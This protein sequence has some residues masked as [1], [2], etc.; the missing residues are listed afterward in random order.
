MNNKAREIANT[1]DKKWFGFWGDEEKVTMHPFSIDDHVDSSWMPSDREKLVH[2]LRS[3]P[4]AIMAQVGDSK[5]GLCNEL[6]TGSCYRSDGEW[7]WTD[8]LAHMVE[9]HFFILPD[10]FVNHIREKSYMPPESISVS[11]SDLPWPDKM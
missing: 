10:S 11:I 7:L 5:C 1:W 4:V 2:Y 3:S 9:K 8:D 6:I